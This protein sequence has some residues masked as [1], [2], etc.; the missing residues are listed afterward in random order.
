VANYCRDYSSRPTRSLVKGYD[1]NVCKLQL[2]LQPLA[3]PMKALLAHGAGPS[4]KPCMQSDLSPAEII[5]G[6]PRLTM[7]QPFL[8]GDAALS[9]PRS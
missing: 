9:P 6:R 1:E 5:Q 7:C 3:V 2:L 8:P 4:G